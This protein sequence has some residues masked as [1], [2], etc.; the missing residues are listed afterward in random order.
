MIYSYKSVDIWL[1][2]PKSAF[3]QLKKGIK[4]LLFSVG[5]GLSSPLYG[6][7]G[8]ESIAPAEKQPVVAYQTENDLYA[9]LMTHRAEQMQPDDLNEF[10]AVAK[11]ITWLDFTDSM[12]CY[13]PEDR[14]LTYDILDK[15]GLIL[16]LTHYLDNP[17]GQVVFSIERD[18]SF[19][20]AGHTPIEKL[21]IRIRHE[22]DQIIESNG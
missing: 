15:S 14:Q 4:I 13:E 3:V 7:N 6:F 8:E 10:W 2:L 11:E 22:V 17:K 1:E 20:V 19:L 12:V 9:S 16:H 18:A 21:G 5:L